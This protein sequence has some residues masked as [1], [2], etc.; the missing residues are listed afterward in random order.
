MHMKTLRFHQVLIASPGDTAE[1]RTIAGKVVEEINRI[2][3]QRHGVWLKSLMWETDTYSATGEDGQAV[4]NHQFGDTY[5]AFVG[6]MRERFG[7][8]TPRHESGTKEEYDRAYAR[9]QQDPASVDIGFYFSSAPISRE[10]E[11]QEALQQ[12][13]KVLAFQEELGG[14]GTVYRK[15]S[16]IDEFEIDIR[17]H[18]SRL[19][20]KWADKLVTVPHLTTGAEKHDAPTVDSVMMNLPPLTEETVA[21]ELNIGS[22]YLN[23]ANEVRTQIVQ[24]ITRFGQQSQARTQLLED[25]MAAKDPTAVWHAVE[26]GRSVESRE[27]VELGDA[28]APLVIPFGQYYLGA[29]LPWSL[30]AAY[31]AATKTDLDGARRLA[32][33]LEELRSAF[34]NF[35]SA[36]VGWRTSVNASEAGT[37]E[38]FRNRQHCLY[39][40]DALLAE[41]GRIRSLM[42]DVAAALRQA[43]E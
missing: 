30:G 14:R 37:L 29:L 40:V 42:F 26:E 18:L 39:A 2:W 8:P 32:D 13:Q 1:E 38:V 24:A 41:S 9:H 7:S 28:I 10:H 25:A 15:Y 19:M 3:G 27:L 16:N 23:R 20:Q 12:L 33:A 31:T 11:N 35:T 43:A 17:L 22:Y 21:H 36:L 34:D 6:I 5:D 4:I